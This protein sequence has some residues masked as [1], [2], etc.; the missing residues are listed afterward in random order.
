MSNLSRSFVAAIV[1]GLPTA[2]ADPCID[3]GLG[4]VNQGTCP[5]LATATETESATDSSATESNS[6]S[7]TNTMSDSLDSTE[8]MSG[9]QSSTATESESGGNLWCVDADGDGY[10]DPDMCTQSDDMPPG[11]VP[12]DDDCDDTNPNTFPGAAPNDDPDAC[13]K[14]EDDDDWGDDDPP[15]G[16]DPGTDCDDENPDA[17]PGA[18]ENEPELC[19]VDADDDG[20]GDANPPGGGGGG[21][22]GPQ[23]GSDCYDSNPQLN[24]DTL[25]LTVFLPYNGG[26]FSP[27]TINFVNVMDASFDDFVLLQT[28]GGGI[29]NTN[30]VTS[31]F[32]E[33]MEIY[34]NDLNAVRLQTVDYADACG[35]GMGVITPVGMMPYGPMGDIV[36]GL[37]FGRDG[38]LYGFGHTGDDLRTFDPATGQV[39]DTMPLT[40]DGALLDVVSCGTAR[41]CSQE[42]LLL[43]NG[44][45]QTIYSV[46]PTN[47]EAEVLRDLSMTVPGPWS[48]TGLEYEPTT[49]SVLL[50]TGNELWRVD[51]T[52]DTVDP[53]LIGMF[54]SPVSNLQNLPICMP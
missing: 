34:A 5:S 38:T 11:T 21:G 41:D 36:C 52:D 1:L 24:P 2:C 53:E 3:D 10:G 44:L 51:I 42:R 15:P 33:Q 39:I 22:G 43:A 7:N 19:T 29:P 20:W 23:S 54:P 16:V 30:V 25:Q 27:K 4:Q 14:D 28:P 9:S 50:S 13:M 45:D 40:V 31:T 35:M 46:D 8:S 17:H 6:N 26:A 47:G 37:E 12:N 49:H 32:N 48:P 18:A